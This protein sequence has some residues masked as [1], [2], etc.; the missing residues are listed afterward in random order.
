MFTEI[1]TKLVEIQSELRKANKYKIQLADYDRELEMVEDRLSQL[2]SQY[3]SEHKD[4]IKLERISLTNL[5]ATLSGTKD[6]R[7][8][9]E[10]QELV[11]AQYRLAEAEQTKKNI[12][13]AMR[14][15]R[16]KIDNLEIKQYEYQQ[17]LLQKEKLIK[18]SS[19][20][21]AARVFE[22]S[23]EEGILQSR[24]NELN[25]AINAGNRVKLD[26]LAAKR[27]L[28]KAGNWGTWDMLGGG[29]I[30]GIAKHRNISLAQEEL[31]RAQT[32]MREFQ[33][34]LLDVQEQAD[35]EIEVSG[36]LKFADFFLD[37]LFVDYIV[38]NKIKSAY[39]QTEN[40]HNNVQVILKR[41]NTQYVANKE[42][43]KLV[44]KEKQEILESI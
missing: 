20:P 41:L 15:V 3:E 21:Y 6:V 18:A 11:T 29:F 30:S 7:L 2:R 28:A 32:S 36:M 43:L 1:N 44:Q 25:E 8:S 10:K 40:Q 42:K 23:E 9:Q 39:Y 5:L 38:Q 19:L 24:L 37:G 14:S 13:E 35:T 34:E 4:V 33:K 16:N 26:L 17:L 22:L 12:E 27:S 31:R